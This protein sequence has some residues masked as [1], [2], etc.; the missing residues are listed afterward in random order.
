MD[1]LTKLL[2]APPSSGRDRN[3]LAPSRLSNT[4]CGQKD[5][6]RH[7]TLLRSATDTFVPDMKR[8]L[9]KLLSHG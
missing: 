1:F 7:A 8:K 2:K 9:R 5:R 3:R 6:I 4:G